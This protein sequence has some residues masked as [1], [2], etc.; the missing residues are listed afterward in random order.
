MLA[1]SEAERKEI[2]DK[3]IALGEKVELLLHEEATTRDAAER[4]SEAARIA[5]RE[6]V[7]DLE[8]VG[9]CVGCKGSGG[10]MLPERAQSAEP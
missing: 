10:V 6:A 7:S 2:R 5:V 1:E 9:L 4:D 8:Q 3:Y